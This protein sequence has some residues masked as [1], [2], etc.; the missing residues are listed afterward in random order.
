MIS[1]KNCKNSL[2]D[3]PDAKFCRFCG[4]SLDST[5]VPT[6]VQSQRR[7]QHKIKIAVGCFMAILVIGVVYWRIPEPTYATKELVKKFGPSIVM[8]QSYDSKGEELAF[9]SGIILSEDGL[10]VTNNHVVK[11]AVSGIV[12][13]SSG[14]YFPIDKFLFQ[15]DLYDIASLKVDA[16]NL[17]YVES[18]DGNLSDSVG[19]K[20]VCIGNPA[21]LNNSVSD[22]IISAIR[23]SD[24]EQFI[25]TTAPISSGSS[26]G[27]MFN[28][29]GKLVGITTLTYTE[30]Q[31]INFAV[32]IKYAL[33]HIYHF[34]V[35]EKEGVG[36]SQNVLW[37]YLESEKTI[38][39][40]LRKAF[41][42]QDAFLDSAIT[43]FVD[44]R[45]MSRTNAV[46]KLYKDADMKKQI[47]TYINVK[48]SLETRVHIHDT[49]VEFY[50]SNFAAKKD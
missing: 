43:K 1:C 11:D 47:D 38:I 41:D 49:I 44:R 19:D 31:N 33:S 28:K 6:N 15:D 7:K 27:G 10:I 18:I 9:G 25:Q 32:P 30:G 4:L 23:T 24:F 26:G 20:V 16:K 45:G 37:D 13:V 14:A 29:K 12:K 40:P 22:G 5:T 17:S 35:M 21:G 42:Q 46:K 34:K 3:N 36:V 8:I 2:S 48:N 39:K 50:N